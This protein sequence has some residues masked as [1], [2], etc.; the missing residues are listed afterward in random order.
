MVNVHFGVDSHT[1]CESTLKNAPFGRLQERE[2]EEQ[3]VC[4]FF[5]ACCAGGACSTSW[6]L[7]GECA[8]EFTFQFVAV[9]VFFRDFIF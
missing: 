4:V 3:R 7:K 1:F 5:V 8:R 9:T 6:L 2:S